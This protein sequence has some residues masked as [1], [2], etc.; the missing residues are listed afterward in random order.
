MARLP[1]CQKE[2]IETLKAIRNRIELEK[3]TPAASKSADEV[4][5]AQN[6]LKRLNRSLMAVQACLIG[7]S[8]IAYDKAETVTTHLVTQIV[9]SLE[10]AAGR[11][12]GAPHDVLERTA[13]CFNDGH[14]VWANLR[15]QLK[16]K[17]V[18]GKT[19]MNIGT[20][21]LEE[22]NL[23]HS[24][25]LNDDNMFSHSIRSWGLMVPEQLN[26]GHPGE[27]DTRRVRECLPLRLGKHPEIRIVDGHGGLGRI[28]S[29]E[30]AVE[31]VALKLRNAL[32]SKYVTKKDLKYHN[33]GDVVDLYYWN[34]DSRS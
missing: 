6:H 8:A 20:G 2:A 27:G 33:L 9:H 1:N 23:E 18:D 7:T 11:G 24:R 19:M 34:H 28:R 29:N 15:T 16:S 32:E 30:N 22:L 17:F 21:D 3:V 31:R 10:D 26:A 13:L 14:D 25:L 5:N 12:K 4:E